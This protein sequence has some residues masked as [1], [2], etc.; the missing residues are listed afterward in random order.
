MSSDE[1]I[2]QYLSS[3][4]TYWLRKVKSEKMDEITR[5]P[6]PYQSKPTSMIPVPSHTP[7]YPVGSP[8]YESIKPLRSLPPSYNS[9]PTQATPTASMPVPRYPPT[10]GAYPPPSYPQASY[11]P[12]PPNMPYRPVPPPNQSYRHPPPPVGQSY[13]AP[14]IGQSIYQQVPYSH[15]PPYSGYTPHR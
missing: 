8:T 13:R 1:F 6:L 5:R 12:S 15:R 9:P 4:T 11:H 7:P 3:R 2:N 14:S 10:S